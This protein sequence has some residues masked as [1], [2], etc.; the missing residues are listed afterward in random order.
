MHALGIHYILELYGCDKRMISSVSSIEKHMVETAHRAKAH[1]VSH[2]FHQ[3]EPYGVSGVVILEE[4]HLTLHSWPE[5]N[6]A[7]VD[8]FCCNPQVDFEAARDY[9]IEVLSVQDSSFQVLERGCGVALPTRPLL[10]VV[11]EG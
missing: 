1:I 6:Y 4:S 3:F 11:A 9:L 2:H 7:A 8:L 10:K 5:H